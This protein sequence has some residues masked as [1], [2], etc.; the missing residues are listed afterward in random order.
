[1]NKILI[2]ASQ[3]VIASQIGKCF[4]RANE[5]ITRTRP[6]GTGHCSRTCQS[7]GDTKFTGASVLNSATLMDLII[8]FLIVRL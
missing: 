5:K 4:D 1:M 7:V 6:P 2:I 3:I 8:N